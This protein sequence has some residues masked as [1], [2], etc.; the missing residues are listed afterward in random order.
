MR[1]EI[2]EDQTPF[3]SKNSSKK[4]RTTEDGLFHLRRRY[5]RLQTHILTKSD[6]LKLNCLNDGFVSLNVQLLASRY[7]Y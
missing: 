2:C 5:Y 4:K 3:T 7:V 1:K 6:S